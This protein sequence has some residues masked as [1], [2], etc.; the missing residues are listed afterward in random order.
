[1]THG[2]SFLTSW[3]QLVGPRCFPK[4]LG[5]SSFFYWHPT[6][7]HHF[8]SALEIPFQSPW[9]TGEGCLAWKER[10]NAGGSR[11]LPRSAAAEL[12]ASQGV[13]GVHHVDAMAGHRLFGEGRGWSG[14]NEEILGNSPKVSIHTHSWHGLWLDSWGWRWGARERERENK[15]KKSRR[16][17]YFSKNC[18][19]LELNRYY[20][21]G[22]L[23]NC[24]YF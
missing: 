18:S 24:L 10:P 2:C 4:A 15:K 14:K 16:H 20:P 22:K 6:T 9:G 12:W 11:V 3:I 5:L 13:L 21:V 17:E 1:M 8:T 23:Q 7:S 19:I